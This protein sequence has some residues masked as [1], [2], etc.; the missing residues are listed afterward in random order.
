M[1]LRH[2]SIDL[3]GGRSALKSRL[4]THTHTHTPRLLLNYY[5]NDIAYVRQTP[6]PFG[7]SDPLIFFKTLTT[8][9]G[10]NVYVTVRRAVYYFYKS[11][12]VLMEIGVFFFFINSSKV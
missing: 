3:P 4:N 7:P 12:F 6:L 11:V 1:L 9:Y 2:T 8:P 10:H 5:D